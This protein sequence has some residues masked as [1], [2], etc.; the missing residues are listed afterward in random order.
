M[1]F[2]VLP[3]I[4]NVR[5][6]EA[7]RDPIIDSINKNVETC[8]LCQEPLRV[9]ILAYTVTETHRDA[10]T[11]FQGL[12]RHGFIESKSQ[13]LPQMWVGAHFLIPFKYAFPQTP[14]ILGK[15]LRRFRGPVGTEHSY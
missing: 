5:N 2:I 13:T 8:L 7:F 11:S 12:D 4:C 6:L 1:Y 9:Q 14:S 3:I 10:S 15:L